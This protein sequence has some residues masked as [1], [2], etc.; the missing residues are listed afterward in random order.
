MR[1]EFVLGIDVGRAPQAVANAYRRAEEIMDA[2]FPGEKCQRQVQSD[3]ENWKVT[4]TRISDAQTA[5]D[6]IPKDETPA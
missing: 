6:F 1:S 2:S 3:G 5:I 4:V